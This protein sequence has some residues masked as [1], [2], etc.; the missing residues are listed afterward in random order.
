MRLFT[1]VCA[2]SLVAALG[3][4]ANNTAS[5]D[6]ASA[7]SVQCPLDGEVNLE[8][9]IHDAL[10]RHPEWL[11]E[12]SQ[13]LR[14]KQQADM[15][16]RARTA[17]AQN[18][19]AL[20]SNPADPIAG[21]P[22]GTVTVVEFFDRE[23]P[24]CK[25]IAPD[26]QRLLAENPDVRVVYKEFPILGPGSIAA[27]KAALAAQRQGRYLPF[28][29]ALMADTTPEHQLAESRIMDIAQSVGLDLKRLK[30][31]MAAPDIAAA[32][33]SNKALARALGIN[34]TP[35]LIIGDRFTAG[36]MSYEALRQ[37]VAE[38]RVQKAASAN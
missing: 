12:M 24:F 32:I 18:K 10:L 11:A 35:G 8:Q 15:A 27:A 1:T 14:T 19:A 3:A 33:E 25:R 20:Y 7:A 16:E 2:L 9:T 28:H 5:A 6:I 29:D 31:D 22:S 38:A 30:A 13:A 4:C 34:G 37:A 23:C 17:M 21:N 36:A 26:L